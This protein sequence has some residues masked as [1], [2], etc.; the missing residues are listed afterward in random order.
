MGDATDRHG[1][2]RPA[3]ADQAQLHPLRGT[4]DRRRDPR[5]AWRAAPGCE[6]LRVPLRADRRRRGAD[7]RRRGPPAGARGR[8]RR[9]SRPSPSGPARRASHPDRREP[10]GLGATCAAGDVR[11]LVLVHWTSIRRPGPGPMCG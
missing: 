4:H 11:G 8:P 9:P 5:R 3:L 7:V 2:P 10:R 6:H 1:R